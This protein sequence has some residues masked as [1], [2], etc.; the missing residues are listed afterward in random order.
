MQTGAVI[1]QAESKNGTW[2]KEEAEETG[3]RWFQECMGRWRQGVQEKQ[4]SREESRRIRKDGGF[5][6]FIQNTILPM[7]QAWR[8]VSFDAIQGL[9]EMSIWMQRVKIR[10]MR[11]IS[12]EPFGP[13]KKLKGKQLEAKMKASKAARLT[14]QILK[15]TDLINQNLNWRIHDLITRKTD[16]ELNEGNPVVLRSHDQNCEKKKTDPN[17]THESAKFSDRAIRPRS[18]REL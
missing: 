15:W 13:R 7:W 1:K 11:N 12:E 17:Q 4:I 2:S 18:R 3:R 10:E 6:I 8:G 14:H 5:P 16:V 9:Y